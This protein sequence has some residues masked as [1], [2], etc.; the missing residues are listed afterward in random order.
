MTE[1][2]L[3]DNDDTI[4]FCK[5]FALPQ[6]KPQHVVKCTFPNAKGVE[7][8]GLYASFTSIPQVITQADLLQHE[9]VVCTEQLT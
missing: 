2:T 6:D 8:P 4:Y 7:S 3:P 9:S 5:L 1:H